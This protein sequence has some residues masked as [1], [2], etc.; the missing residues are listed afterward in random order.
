[1]FRNISNKPSK[2]LSE[3]TCYW[4]GETRHHMSTS[5]RVE[6]LRRGTK[7]EEETRIIWR[8]RIRITRKSA[9]LAKGTTGM[10]S[11]RHTSTLD[12]NGTKTLML[13]CQDLTLSLHP[14]QVVIIRTRKWQI[15]FLLHQ[16]PQ[17]LSSTPRATKNGVMSISWLG[18]IRYLVSLQILMLIE[19]PL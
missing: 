7:Y 17:D 19:I 12:K 16:E 2:D 14:F 13:H 8:K 9:T 6:K 11:T 10:T 4:C 18:T 3:M 1:M 5:T 15:T